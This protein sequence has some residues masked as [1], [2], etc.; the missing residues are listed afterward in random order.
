[1]GN[2]NHPRINPEKFRPENLVKCQRRIPKQSLE[3]Y[4]TKIPDKK[5]QKN[6]L[7]Y[8]NH[9]RINPEKFRPENLVKCQRI[10]PNLSLEKYPTKI[11][12][13]CQRRFP[14]RILEKH[15]TKIPEKCRPEIR[16][17]NQVSLTKIRKK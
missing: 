3:K 17:K 5:W 11:P 8:P 15:L 12:V 13:K 14:K 4:P 1:M 9:P 16:I 6:P 2:P 7:K 10:I